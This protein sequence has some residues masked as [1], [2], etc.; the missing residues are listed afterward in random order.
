MGK[1]IG[2]A[3][4]LV[5]LLGTLLGIGSYIT[6]RNYGARTEIE[7][8]AKVTD[9]RQM[10]GKHST[11]IGEMAQV[12]TMYKDDL[13]EVYT[14]AMTG[15]YGDDGSTAVMQWIKEQN[16]NMD[17][18]L[19]LR[20]S[21]KIEANRD[22]FQNAQTQLID[23]KQVYEKALATLWSGFW[24]DMAGYPKIDLASIKVISST[25]ANEAFEA[26]VDDGIQVRRQ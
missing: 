20:I 5:L 24:L 18:A 25:H 4:V 16:P 13:V 8:N 9:N 6:Y 26:G 23:Q 7:L 22:E 19:Y 17:S 10:L 14:A 15:R 2:G 3:L 21:Q 11:Q 1:I 12:T